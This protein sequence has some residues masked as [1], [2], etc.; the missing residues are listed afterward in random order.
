MLGLIRY[1][2][3]GELLTYLR[4]LTH[5]QRHRLK[6]RLLALFT[7]AELKSVGAARSRHKIKNQRR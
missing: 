5:S 6:R 1:T 3:E 4:T 2:T 7:R